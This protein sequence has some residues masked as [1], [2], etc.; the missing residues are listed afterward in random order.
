MRI[1]MVFLLAIGAGGALAFGT[2]NYMQQLPPPGESVAT[3]KVVI[4][5]TDLQIGAELQR[6]DLRV[7]DW[8]AGAVPAGAFSSADEAR[9][10]GGGRR[11]A[12]GHSQGAA[13]GLGPRQ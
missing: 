8:P 5:A 11:P 10:Q 3:Q 2:Y 9:V 1:F 4:A 6:D 7:I 12:A 13:R